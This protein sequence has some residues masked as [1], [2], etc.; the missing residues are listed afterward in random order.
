MA[1]V[2]WQDVDWNNVNFT[3]FDWDTVNLPHGM[4]VNDFKSN[5]IGWDLENVDVNWAG[6]FATDHNDTEN[7][8]RL[9]SSR[10]I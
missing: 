3:N 5:Y 2:D 1:K 4:D 10:K 8:R 7:R 9:A 6:N